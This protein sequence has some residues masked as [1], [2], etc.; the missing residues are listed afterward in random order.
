MNKLNLG[1]LKSTIQLKESIS[2]ILKTASLKVGVK[3]VCEGYLKRLNAGE[4]EEM[5]YESFINDMSKFSSVDSIGKELNLIDFRANQ[6]KANLGIKRAIYEMKNSDD[7]VIANMIESAVTNYLISKNDESIKNLRETAEIFKGRSGVDAILE[8]VTFDEYN[9][10]ITGKVSLLKLEEGAVAEETLYTQAQIDDIVKQKVDE[11]L[12]TE[13][14]NNAQKVKS[15]SQLEDRLQLSNTIDTLIAKEGR[16]QKLKSFCESYK[17]EIRNGK[18]EYVLYESFISGLSQFSYLNAVDTELS[19]MNDRINKYKQDID[20]RK[21]LE[22]MLQTESYYIVPLIEECVASYCDNKNATT[23]MML[24]QACGNFEYDPFVKDIMR[25]VANDKSK[26]N[27]YLGESVE[28]NK[29]SH[30]EAVFSPVLYIKENESV[31]NVD[32]V[33]YSRKGANITRVPKSDVV[34]LDESF[35]RTAEALNESNVEYDEVNDGFRIYSKNGKDS[36]I[37]NESGI[38]VNGEKLALETLNNENFMLVENYNGNGEFYKTIRT[39]R[40]NFGTIAQLDF[41]KRVKLN[42]SE[43]AV[44]IFKVNKTICMALVNEDK[45]T[46]FYR[47]VNPIKCKDLM[48]E[49]MNFNVDAMFEEVMPNQKK[50][51]EDIDETKSAYE[52]YIAELESKK[53]ELQSLK[54][55]DDDIDKDELDKAE[56]LIDKEIA[57]AKEDYMKYQKDADAELGKNAKSDDGEGDSSDDN[58]GDGDGEGKDGEGDIKDVKSDVDGEVTEPISNTGDNVLDNPD[59]NGEE[60]LNQIKDMSADA[61]EFDALLDTPADSAELERGFDVVKVSF[62]KNIKTGTTSPAGTVIMTVPMVNQNGDIKDEIKMIRFTVGEDKQPIINNDYMSAVMYTAIRSAILASPDLDGVD[63]SSAATTPAEGED[64]AS[65]LTIS[66]TVDNPELPAESTEGAPVVAEPSEPTIPSEPTDVPP[67]EVDANAIAS[68]GGEAE[69]GAGDS[70]TDPVSTLNPDASVDGSDVATPAEPAEPQSP[71]EIEGTSIYRGKD[72]GYIH[73]SFPIKIGIAYE[74]ILPIEGG[75]FLEDL[76]KSKIECKEETDPALGGDGKGVVLT[77]KNRAEIEFILNYFKKWLEIDRE[78]FFKGFPELRQFES[79]NYKKA[80]KLYESLIT[81]GTIEINID[82]SDDAF[83]DALKS[84]DIKFQDDDEGLTIVANNADEFDKICGFLAS[85]KEDIEE[86]DL[87]DELTTIV[88]DLSTDEALV[89]LP[90]DGELISNLDK[91]GIE[92]T[93]EGDDVNIVVTSPEE[94]DVVLSVADD[95]E[96]S[97]PSLDELAD[98]IKDGGFVTEGLK[99]TVEDTENHKKITF[100]TDDLD[101]DGEKKDDEEN[102]EKKDGDGDATFGDDNQLYNSKEEAE[103][104]DKAKGEGD[105]SQ[106]QESSKPKKK[107]FVFKAK[108][109]H[110]SAQPKLAEP[111][112]GDKVYYKNQIGQVTDKNMDG[113]LTVLVKGSTIVC[114][115]SEVKAV[116]PKVDL[117]KDPNDEIITQVK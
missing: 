59:T 72:E 56:E 53:K 3:D 62:D 5:L 2:N 91:E 89:S 10:K 115:P 54:E 69:I 93:E 101:A 23:R 4:H 49:H 31:F 26:E 9:R 40:E 58:T 44:D 42:E 108:K 73:T 83:I 88:G 60:T 21:I 25:I 41:V 84:E 45:T 105:N 65:S 90:Y 104:A 70:I 38:T 12:K 22:M 11:A 81:E 109:V 94:A 64:T 71:A 107:K 78:S 68:D 50:L 74:D 17:N 39:I 106:A 37:V 35:R 1:M 16:N 27:L 13:R 51:Q 43:K 97:S 18:S 77:L 92:Y 98:L 66:N 99:I 87:F 100:D 8:A 80:N 24:R 36:A 79:F 61:T 46:E 6:E 95:L 34:K 85:Y 57:A 113:T 86:G 28:N 20:L 33:Y 7:A 67:T 15:M 116:T 102:G 103:N 112:V 32:G 82:N 110:E 75:K 47:D 55:A 29:F 114:N 19:A 96:L 63:F 30:T 14:E 48:N 76:V 52:A 111:H 117:V